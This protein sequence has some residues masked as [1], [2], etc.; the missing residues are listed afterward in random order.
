MR[1]RLENDWYVIDVKIKTDVE[2][3]KVHIDYNGLGHLLIL[4]SYSILKHSEVN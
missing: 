2:S 1:L 4:A 3:Q